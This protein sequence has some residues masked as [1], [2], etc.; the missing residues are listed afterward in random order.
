M[1]QGHSSY[2]S[3]ASFPSWDEAQPDG[4][5]PPPAVSY[6]APPAVDHAAP[7]A[8]DHAPAPVVDFAPPPV[9][10][11][12]QPGV[13]GVPRVETY[14]EAEAAY[15]TATVAVTMRY[16]PIAFLFGIRKPVLTIDGQRV[17]A[18]WKR[19]VVVPV[20]PGSHL[21]HV[22]VPYLLPPRAGKADLP[23]QL[24]PGQAVSLEYRAP[25]IAFMR[26]A[27]GTSPQ[28]YPGVAATVV[29]NAVAV[30]GLLAAG[31]AGFTNLGSRP[32]F[33]LPAASPP[34]PS[35]SR[36]EAP[37][38]PVAPT[39]PAVP[40]FPESSRSAAAGTGLREDA[41]D[42]KLVGA[43]FGQGEETSTATSSEWPFAFRIPDDWTCVQ[44]KIDLP[45]TDA[46]VCFDKKTE[47]N[48]RAG[49]ILRRCPAAC[50]AADRKQLDKDWFVDTDGVRRADDDTRFRQTAKN[51]AGRYQLEL[52]HFFTDP[53]SGVKYQVG[54]DARTVPAQKATAQKVVNDVLSQTTF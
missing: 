32:G 47:K 31:L 43:T 20:N 12:A 35:P 51:G 11:R 37:A 45:E 2:P 23:V 42:R 52:S 27:L 53:A 4:Y 30:T 44:G 38:F 16:A 22:H 49:I 8:V 50:D 24:G 1:S 39:G 34:S 28:R 26:G 13:Y 54:V 29:I 25:L 40:T 5:A 17:R 33:A 18:G 19:R 41:P 14:P 46:M 36:F 10:P 3:F 48:E 9:Y 15:G 6:A 7:P 21:V